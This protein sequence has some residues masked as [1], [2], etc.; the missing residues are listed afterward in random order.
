M[1]LVKLSF[2]PFIGDREEEL[3]EGKYTIYHVFICLV[4][5]THAESVYWFVYGFRRE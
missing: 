1:I 4:Y 3:K 2:I 5:L